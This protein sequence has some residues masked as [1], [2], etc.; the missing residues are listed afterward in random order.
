MDIFESVSISKIEKME[1]KKQYE[2][3]LALLKYRLVREGIRLG[4]DMKRDLG[5]ISEATGIPLY[6]LKELGKLLVEE[7]FEEIFSK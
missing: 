4:P 2:I 5:N 6:E 3:A 7:F 1:K